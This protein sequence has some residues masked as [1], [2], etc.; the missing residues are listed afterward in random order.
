[1]APKTLRWII[2]SAALLLTYAA[3][4]AIFPRGSF[5]LTAIGDLTT[6]ALFSWATV[7][8]CRN[9]IRDRET[10]AFW[11]FMTA[12]CSIWAINLSMWVYVEVLLRREIPDPFVGD[13][14]RKSGV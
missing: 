1:M 7:V 8:A 6:L 3:L 11:G 4:P 13:I 5:P 9:A 14:D 2:P 10:R 12:G